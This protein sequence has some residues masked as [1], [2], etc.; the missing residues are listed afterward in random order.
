M[1]V[2]LVSS[3]DEEKL[4]LA[5]KPYYDKA[6]PGDYDHALRVVKLVKELLKTEKGD[7]D[8]LIAAAYLHDI[9]YSG[10]ILSKPKSGFQRGSTQ[11]APTYETW[12]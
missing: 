2:M 11:H 3:M 7:R 5:A 10:A 12:R 8:A 9:G 1:C 6:R 4:R